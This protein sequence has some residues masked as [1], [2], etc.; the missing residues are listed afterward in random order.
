MCIRDRLTIEDSLEVNLEVRNTGDLFGAEIVQVYVSM[1]GSKVYRPV[2]ELK[3]F[4]KVHL[5]PQE[6]QRVK[7]SIDVSQLAVFDSYRRAWVL[8]R[9]D[10][11][12]RVGSS[13]RDVRLERTIQ[14]QSEQ[15]LSIEFIDSDRPKI[16][17]GKLLVD[18]QTFSSM[19]GRP[20]PNIESSLPFHFNSSLG[21]IGETFLGNI[22]KGQVLKTFK[23]RIVT[24]SAEPLLEKM[25]EETVND[26]PLRCLVLFS[27]GKFGFKS[28]SVLVSLLNGRL[29]DAF[30]GFFL[31][32][33]LGK[34][35]ATRNLKPSDR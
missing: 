24:R 16:S 34:D 22:I 20:L 7:L 2:N 18:D 29:V 4:V 11:L 28:L 17:E 27:N 30:K 35:Q 19:L 31:N 10:Y 13:S 26:M 6:R 9:G 3:A 5:V 32:R 8:E 23:K 12:I 25:F 33:T 21:E 14:V 1:I 15:E